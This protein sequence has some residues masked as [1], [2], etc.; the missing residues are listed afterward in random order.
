MLIGGDN[1]M[2]RVSS[3]FEVAHQYFLSPSDASAIVSHQ[4]RMIGDCWEEVCE[5]ANLNEIDR[6]LLWGRQCL[7]PFAFEDLTGENASLKTLADE[8]RSK[9]T[10]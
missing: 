7:N 1:R 2:S 5:Q 9:N 10:L 8:I 3:C 4:L 6:R